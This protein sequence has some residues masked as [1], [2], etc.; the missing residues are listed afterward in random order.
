MKISQQFPSSETFSVLRYKRLRSVEAVERKGIGHPDSLADLIAD[1][2]S[3]RY[4]RECLSRWGLILNHWVDKVTLVGCAAQV[5]F[6]RFTIEKPASIYLFGKISRGIGADSIDIDELFNQSVRSV[7]NEALGKTDIDRHVRLVVENTA[8]SVTADHAPGFY[9]PGSLAEAQHAHVGDRCANDTVLCSAYV[10]RGELGPLA[11]ELENAVTHPDYG[12]VSRCAEIG[13]DV[14]VVLVRQGRALDMTLCVPCHA[15]RVASRRDYDRLMEHVYQEIRQFADAAAKERGLTLARLAMNSKDTARSSYICPFGTA[16]GKGDCG[17]VGRG[18]RIGG[19]IDVLGANTSEAPAGKNP[20]HHVG[21]LYT[22]GAQIIA[23]ECLS[24][25]NAASCE[26]LLATDN[27]R[28]LLMPR[29][30][31]VE[32]SRAVVAKS[33]IREVVQEVLEQLP[34]FWRS[35]ITHDSCDRFRQGEYKMLSDIK[36]D[37]ARSAA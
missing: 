9:H 13:T 5:T 36:E 31:S 7:L 15:E 16:F 23:R 29:C 2:F 32:L 3:R 11:Q 37:E 4:S 33:K 1:D 8:A 24:R 20:L 18:N 30:V 34:Q 17:A 10:E 26:V 22:I 6:G 12:I 21:K 25:F 19:V 35:Y 28:P 27:G 14:K